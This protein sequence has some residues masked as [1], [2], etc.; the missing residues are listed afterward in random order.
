MI[1]AAQNIAGSTLTVVKNS[2]SNDTDVSIFNDV[3]RTNTSDNISSGFYGQVN[4]ITSNSNFND[5]LIFALE[6]IAR[7]NGTGNIT[8]LYGSR[9]KVELLGAGN[10]DFAISSLSDVNILGT[11][12]IYAQYIRGQRYRN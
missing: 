5:N 2:T 8:S 1:G 4:R 7:K 11:E 10:V 3:I 12:N 9:D 6:N